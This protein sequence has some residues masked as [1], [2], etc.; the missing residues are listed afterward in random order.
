MVDVLDHHHAD[1][2][3]VALVMVE[4]EFH[5]SRQRLDGRVL[6]VELRLAAPHLPVGFSRAREIEPL[7]VAEIVVDHALAGARACGDL[8]DPGAGEPVL[9]ELLRRDLEDVARALPGPAHG[10]GPISILRGL[11]S[12]T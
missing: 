2:L 5:Q 3:L 1:E 10:R 12:R 11:G 8:V 7:L 9:S 6:R 4:S